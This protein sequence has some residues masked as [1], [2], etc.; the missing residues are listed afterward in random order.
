MMDVKI[1]LK[2]EECALSMG[3]KSN[4]A[5]V[6]DAQT[7]LSKEECAKGMEQR[8]NGAA[9]KDAPIK[10]NVKES[11]GDMGQTAIYTTNRLPSD[12]NSR[13]LQPL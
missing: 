5:V 12:Q 7:M 1:N 10:P 8:G 4:N 13:I 2:M 9:T 6:K 3:Q 11:V